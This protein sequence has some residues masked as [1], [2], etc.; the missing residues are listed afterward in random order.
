[1]FRCETKKSST[2]ATNRSVRPRRNGL[3]A[4]E[5]KHLN[6]SLF[7][8]GGVIFEAKD[9]RQMGQ[10]KELLSAAAA[11]SSSAK[12]P[13]LL[14]EKEEAAAAAA[15]SDEQSI[16]GLFEKPGCEW[17]LIWTVHY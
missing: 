4:S 11:I 17:A 8:S 13:P 2:S 3:A 14:P 15:F 1:M 6:S 5:S 12:S 7:F 16:W 9:S 10:A